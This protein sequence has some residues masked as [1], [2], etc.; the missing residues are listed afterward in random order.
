MAPSAPIFGIVGALRAFPQRLA[1]RAVATRGGRLR[2]GITR[3]THRVVLGRK[4]LDKLSEAEIETRIDALNDA[5]IKL[6]S[7]N[8]FLRWL[9]LLETPERSAMS[10]QSL[11]DQ[12]RLDG[13]TL[14]RLALF[15]AFEHD[16]EPFSFR[17]VILAKKYAGLIASG[18]TWGAVVRSVHH[19][20]PVASLTALSLHPGGPQK[21]YAAE[22]ERRTE[23]DGQRL[24][25]LEPAD[26]DSEQYFTLA[27]QAEMAGLFA[28][29][30][31]LY[32]RCLA[33]DP[34]DSVAAYNRANC[35]RALGEADE[36]GAAY[37]LAIK[38]DPAFVEAW[39]NYA[40]LLKD[41]GRIG[42]ARSHLLRAI[43]IDAGYADAVYNL[44]TLEFDA[45]DLPAARQ[46]WS[47]Y[48]EL[49]PQSDWA[50]TAT[51]GIA[52]IDLNSRKSAG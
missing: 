26:D 49:D 42:A 19:A 41:E 44:A 31:V 47:R 32:A 2:R 23:L 35:F 28:E 3:Q 18:A 38:I 8:G 33:L 16:A 7:E 1:A 30:T 21:I 6:L 50:K 27:E 13:G 48:L 22:G 46:W 17:D 12:S 24:L 45:K 5:G 40:A 11:L 34:S 52:F 39:F 29:A 25:P 15:D 14:D 37:T 51:R 10:R 36:A 9:H 20:G 43:A 4:L